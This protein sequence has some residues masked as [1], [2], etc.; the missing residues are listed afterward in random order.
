MKSKRVRHGLQ[1]AVC[2]ALLSAGTLAAAAPR[3]PALGNFARL[4]SLALPEAI[5]RLGSGTDVLHPSLD[6]LSGR[7]Q[8]LVHLSGPSVARGAASRN[9]VESEQAAFVSR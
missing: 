8:V 7:Q 1:W 2:S 9:A 4:S 3:E 5:E 6:G